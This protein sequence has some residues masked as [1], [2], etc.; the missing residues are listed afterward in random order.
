MKPSKRN[1][2]TFLAEIRKVITDNAQ[3]T[4]GHLIAQLNPK[5]RGWAN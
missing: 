1:I 5:I 3:A 2:S 4:E